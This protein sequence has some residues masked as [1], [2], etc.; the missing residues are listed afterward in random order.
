MVNTNFKKLFR[1][2]PGGPVAKTA[3]S[4]GRGPGSVPGQGIRSHMLQ[5][6]LGAAK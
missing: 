2:F 1:D 4:Q 6:R 3:R 5:V